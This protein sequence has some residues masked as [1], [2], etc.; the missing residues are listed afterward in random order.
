MNR[1][2]NR[3]ALVA[4]LALG[5][6]AGAAPDATLTLAR[7]LAESGDH[8][9]AAVEFRRLALETEAA[10]DRGAYY[11]MAGYEYWKADRTEQADKMLGLSE[12]VAPDREPE[13][14]W[15]RAENSLKRNR[16]KEAGFYFESLTA[17]GRPE[18]IRLPATKKL[19][20]VRLRERDYEGARKALA[21]LPAGGGRGLAAVDLYEKGRD[22]S[23]MVGGL[24]GLVPGMGYAYS[25]E[26]ANATRSLFLNALC[27]WG[28]VSFAE[29]E[30]WGGV[31]VVG[32]AEFTF[33]SGSIYG[34]VDAAARYNQQRL[35]A[36]T[37]T[38]QG[39]GDF[40]P[41]FSALP[42]L[43]LRFEF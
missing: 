38:M 36:A 19:A 33:Y 34:G 8:A 29:D 40:Q 20:A 17:P 37:R 6:A 32:F 25:G 18:K 5:A 31:A 2:M 41:D 27:I 14:Y 1:W 13:V 42:V 12:D 43:S 26:Y 22:K 4:L 9:Q 10:A 7:E 16:P 24:L 21:G 28:I 35:Q 15:L 23:P 11:W 3:A 30:T 39:N